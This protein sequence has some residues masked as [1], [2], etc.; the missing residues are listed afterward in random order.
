MPA[1][2]PPPPHRPRIALP[3][4]RLGS[5]S[6]LLESVPGAA[7]GAAHPNPASRRRLAHMGLIYSR[8]DAGESRGQRSRPG[9][10][11]KGAFGSGRRRWCFGAPRCQ[12][13]GQQ[14][15]CLALLDVPLQG[16]RAARALAEVARPPLKGGPPS[17]APPPPARGTTGG[18]GWTAPG[19]CSRGAAAP[20]RP[21]IALPLPRARPPTPLEGKHVAGPRQRGTRQPH[22]RRA[23]VHAWAGRTSIAAKERR[24][25]R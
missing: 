9:S 6:T 4:P 11:V 10:G 21:Q 18:F 20:Q 3:R 8:A 7:A 15:P 25:R 24:R 14:Q 13:K 17:E 19:D 5:P 1:A 12:R 22:P 23:L 2:A 16:G